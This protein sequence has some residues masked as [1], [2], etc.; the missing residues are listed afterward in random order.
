MSLYSTVC[1]GCLVPFPKR[2]GLL[3]HLRQSTNPR[4]RAIRRAVY[5]DVP[6]VHDDEPMDEDHADDEEG[7]EE[8][9]EPLVFGGDFYGVN[10]QPE[11]FSGFEYAEDIDDL[12]YHPDQSDT[13]SDTG[14]DSDSEDDG[15]QQ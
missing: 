11:D 3:N 10:Y 7:E 9:N 6:G 5:E 13:D 14:S 2:G 8:E 12:D 1:P 15:N 4:Y